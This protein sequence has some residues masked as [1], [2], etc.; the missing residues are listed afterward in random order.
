MILKPREETVRYCTL[1]GLL[2]VSP[3]QVKCKSSESRSAR[4]QAQA[5]AYTERGRP[6]RKANTEK[7]TREYGSK[8]GRDNK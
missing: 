4:L 6:R 3:A 5:Q 7:G 1:P 2:C 8:T